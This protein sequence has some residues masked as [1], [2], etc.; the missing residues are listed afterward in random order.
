[1]V[2]ISLFKNQ[3][4]QQQVSFIS[5]VTSAASSAPQQFAH[6]ITAKTTVV[7]PTFVQRLVRAFG[8]CPQCPVNGYERAATIAKRVC[9]VGAGLVGVG[10]LAYGAG[11]GLEY[12]GD[13]AANKFLDC[14]TRLESDAALECGRDFEDVMH[15][16]GSWTKTAGEYGQVV[17]YNAA[18]YTAT[19]LHYSLNYTT[20]LAKKATDLF[21]KPTE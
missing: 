11:K 10:A 19:A 18:K 8:L 14:K 7:E 17:P 15:T 3:Q 4:I 1:M 12:V 20:G 5:K 9:I 16:L 13:T 6:W 21:A 2:S